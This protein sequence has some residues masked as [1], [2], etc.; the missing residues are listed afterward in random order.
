MEPAV[1]S[2]AIDG[3]TV[4]LMLARGIRA[5]TTGVTVDYTAQSATPIKDR[6]GNAAVAFTGRAVTARSAGQ[7]RGDR[8][9]D[10]LGIGHGR[11]EADRDRV[12]HRRSGRARVDRLHR[13]LASHRREQRDHHRDEHARDGRREQLLHA[14]RP[15]RR[16]AHQGEG[17]LRGLPRQ[18]GGN[19][20][21]CVPPLRARHVDCR[22]RVRHADPGRPG[23]A[24][25]RPS[26]G[27]TNI[28][29]GEIY[30]HGFGLE[31]TGSTL[32]DKTFSIK[33]TEYSIVQVVV[34]APGSRI[35]GNLYFTTAT[36]LPTSATSGIQLHVCG[37]VFH[38][39]DGPDSGTSPD[40]S[41]FAAGSSYF[42]T[43][44]SS[45]LDWSGHA[46]RR[47]Y[48]SKGDTRAPVLTDVIVDVDTLTMIY[49]EELKRTDP[50]HTGGGTT[51]PY[52]VGASG[53]SP[54]TLSDVRAGVGPNANRVTMTLIPSAEAGQTIVMSYF[55]NDATAAS[56]AQDL[57]ATP[58]RL[59]V[60]LP[61]R[62][63]TSAS[64]APGWTT[65]PS[66]TPRRSTPSATSSAWTSP[67][68]S[69]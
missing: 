36:D 22:F 8:H 33:G 46:T 29:E 37:D 32:S 16:Q 58:P 10:G 43:W 68:T 38:F 23:A 19:R 47:V 17:Y 48:L 4:R 12:R 65:W 35:A 49:D 60:S 61:S 15:R 6:A 24:L 69:P 18:L 9:G 11:P 20:K 1:R 59:S 55:A 64:T 30:T 52:T 26:G 5:N 7:Q 39:G 25:D 63:G 54:F 41:Y 21:R 28:S 3:A 27:W 56:K 62:C 40:A 66:P 31:N 13:H 44:T 14:R 45:G 34:G 2:V 67:S 50:V 51:S 42:Y 53:S 57:A